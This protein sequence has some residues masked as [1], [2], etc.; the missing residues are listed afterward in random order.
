MGE[1]SH[2]LIPVACVAWW[3]AWPW[4]L[5][6]RPSY[7]LP[8]NSKKSMASW[9]VVSL[10]PGVGFA[11]IDKEARTQGRVF[12][13]HDAD[14]DQPC[15]VSQSMPVLIDAYNDRHSHPN[16]LHV[17]S[18]YRVL[19]G[20]SLSAVHKNHGFVVRE[21]AAT[22]ELNELIGQF[23]GCFVVTKEGDAWHLDGADKSAP[24][25]PSLRPGEKEGDHELPKGETDTNAPDAPRVHRFGLEGPQAAGALSV[26]GER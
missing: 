18:A 24:Q 5:A 7:V 17:T 21:R 4:T 13:M 2:R 1:A 11:R 19:R 12:C 8:A 10:P 9:C 6:T 3:E 26:G 25:S 23:P 14:M 22:K 16:R 20:Q 15:W